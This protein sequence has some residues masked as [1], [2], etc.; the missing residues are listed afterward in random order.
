MDINEL[1]NKYIKNG[2]DVTDAQSKVCQDLILL[3]IGK[4]KYARN[5]TIKGGVVMHTI[6]NDLRRA[7]RDL[8]LDFIKYSL[9]NSSIEKFIESLNQVE[10]SIHLTISAPIEEL[11]HQDYKGKRVYLLL[12]DSKNNTIETKLDIGIHKYFDL[13]QENYYFDF[14][15]LDS[16]VSLLINSLEQIIV[17]KLKSL[18][19]FGINSTR[20]KDIF[21]LYYL[22]NNHQ[23]DKEK[24]INYIRVLILNDTKVKQETI[25]EINDR[26]VNILNNE[27]F[28][29]KLKNARSNWIDISID[30]VCDELIKYFKTLDLITV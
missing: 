19:K 28:Q 14:D 30:I 24:L 23:L 17:E 4:S 21:D 16:G 3:K 11:N 8:D 9:E 5:V 26:I 20:Y 25:N 29:N 18:L 6:S 22:I 10:N 13:L 1:V 27:K 15:I 2:Y 12:N 7:T